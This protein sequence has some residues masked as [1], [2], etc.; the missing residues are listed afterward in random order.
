MD[1]R[2]NLALSTSQ[3]IEHLKAG[4]QNSQSVARFIDTK[5]GALM[6]GLAA[7]VGL[8]FAQGKAVVE[9]LPYFLKTVISWEGCWCCVPLLFIIASVA[10]I[11]SGGYVF[12]SSIEALSPRNP[13]RSKPSAIFPYLD[14]KNEELH[15]SEK[16]RIDLFRDGGEWKHA[17]EDW[18]NQLERMGEINCE[19]IMN[20]QKAFNGFRFFLYSTPVFFLA[21]LLVQYVI[22]F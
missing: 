12:W 21:C 6:A 20:C 5:I 22:N 4:Y 11:A 15:N 13:G 8:M 18:S 16:E 2:E 1:D 14:K 7:L 10:V 9:S 3:R 17:I 19:K